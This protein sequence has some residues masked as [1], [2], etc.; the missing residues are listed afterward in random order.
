MSIHQHPSIA[1]DGV[2]HRKPQITVAQLFFRAVRRWQRGRIIAELSRLDDQHLD[3]IGIARNDIPRIARKMVERPRRHDDAP[4]P[5]LA[6]SSTDRQ[7]R[8]AA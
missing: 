5:V 8:E 2:N 4:V 3:D 6:A 1:A 7:F